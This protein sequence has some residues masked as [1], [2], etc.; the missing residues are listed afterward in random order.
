MPNVDE[1]LENARRE[2]P[3]GAAAQELIA[4]GEP[5]VEPLI[6][7][8][9][10]VE[11]TALL[12]VL[13]Q[14]RDPK[15]APR[16]AELLDDEDYD[17][18]AAAFE[19]L[20]RLQDP[21]V[22][23]NL[24][25]FLSRPRGSLAVAALGELNDAAAIP[26]LK[27]AANDILASPEYELVASGADELVEA[28]DDSSLVDLSRLLIALFKLGDEELCEHIRPLISYRSADP[29]SDAD[30]VRTEA[31][32]ACQHFPIRPLY[33]LL[34]RAL[35]DPF[36]EVRSAVVDAL[37][38]VGSARSMEILL[39]ARETGVSEP[40]RRLRLRLRDLTARDPDDFASSEELLRWWRLQDYAPQTTYRLGKPFEP[41]D[42]VPLLADPVQKEL[43]ARELQ[44]VTGRDFGYVED[45]DNLTAEELQRRVE[46]WIDRVGPSIEPG[47]LLK[48]GRRQ[49]HEG[50]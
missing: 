43:V 12:G 6:S 20:G 21:S 30:L 5:V 47:S 48:H 49:S 14:L 29:Y 11:E 1:L 18:A 44:I 41:S 3:T 4:A 15:A 13:R 31:V 27:E 23:P 22:V 7:T 50:L 2:G 24:A 35:R 9:R 19:L 37:F 17:L 34:D 45:L 38:Y 42:L 10:R 46:D 40:M 33:P 28:I 36:S 16:V 8:Y 39:K 26:P 32:K 25:A